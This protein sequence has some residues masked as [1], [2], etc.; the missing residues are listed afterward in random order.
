M[1]RR[2]PL[3]QKGIVVWLFGLSGAG[4]TTISSLL[5]EQLEHNGF[6]VAALDG[7]ELRKGISK[8][9]SFSEVDRQENIRRAAEI[10]KIFSNNNIITICSFITPLQKHRNVAA[11]IIGDAYFEVFVDCP[12]DVCFKRDV[13]GL[14]KKAKANQ[15]PDFTGI[16]SGFE[17]PENSCFVLSTAH[18]S[19]GES[20][21]K[22]YSLLLPRISL[23]PEFEALL[24][25]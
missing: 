2:K 23:L 25:L 17:R 13:K 5:K 24:S 8:D 18:E 3:S 21:G 1:N 19:A 15:I 22:V 10:A 12:L 14:Y 20:M 6:T 9:L 16:S 7:D 4:K 11:E